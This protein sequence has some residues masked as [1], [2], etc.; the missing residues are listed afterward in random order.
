MAQQRTPLAAAV[1][2]RFD[3]LSARRG[4]VNAQRRQDQLAHL[5]LDQRVRET[6]EW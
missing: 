6:G 2:R 1:A 4:R 3:L 5:D